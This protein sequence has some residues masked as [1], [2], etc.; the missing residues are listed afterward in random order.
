MN[1]TPTEAVPTTTPWPTWREL[2]NRRATAVLRNGIEVRMIYCAQFHDRVKIGVNAGN[3]ERFVFVRNA[4]ITAYRDETGGWIA[5][6]PW[7]TR[8][9]QPGE[10]ADSRNVQRPTP[11]GVIADYVER[12]GRARTPNIIT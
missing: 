5:I 10:T 12:Y 1:T 3:G 6:L 9:R 7:P 2:A 4:D 8:R 11:I